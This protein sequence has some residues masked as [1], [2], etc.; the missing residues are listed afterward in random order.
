MTDGEARHVILGSGMAAY[1]AG[2]QLDREGVAYTCYDKASYPGGHTATFTRP[3]GF[4]F[5]DGPHL[6]FTKDERIQEIFAGNVGGEYQ[7]I[8][9]RIDNYW[10]GQ[11][12][13]HPAQVNLY[14]VP[15]ELLI[16][17]IVD[18][19]AASQAGDPPTTDYASWSRG[20][21]GT[22]FA[23]TF[24]LVYA[25]KYHTTDGSD[26]TTDWLGP[27]FYRPSLEEL[28]TGALIQTPHRDMHYV[29]HFRY[30]TEGGFAAYLAPWFAR[31]DLRLDHE[32]VGIDP[33]T[34][35]VRFADGS[36]TRYRRLIS[37]MPLP[38]LIRAIE[39]VPRDVR[40]AAERLAFSTAV[41]VNVGVDRERISDT[42]ITYF[43]DEDVIYPRLNFPSMLSP[44][45]V[46]P[47]TSSIQAEIYFSDKYR[48]LDRALD[49]IADQTVADLVR[50][51]VLDAGD[52]ILC[53]EARLVRYANVIY[54]HDRRDALAA[55]H[56]FL[57]DVGIAYCG[58]Y[59]DW[60]HS[61][62]DEAFVSGERAA[63]KTL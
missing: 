4:V 7:T 11:R 12:I 50:T 53:R 21:Y 34:C 35:T 49:D 29:T 33:R 38:D 55:V 41:I 54:D 30:P 8:Q 13:V 44:R 10:H 26:L 19:V 20:A 31:A 14:G 58:R 5:D 37:S 24:P 47:G 59:G 52:R 23:E 22:T 6:S 2:D 9:I 39:G 32:V 43:Y 15:P 1:G 40:E 61:W 25:R 27:R 42:H 45:T 60:D 16:R 17:I 48:P 18:F 28:L 46:P 57:D 51:G 36:E 63:Q 56:G 62:T 3:D